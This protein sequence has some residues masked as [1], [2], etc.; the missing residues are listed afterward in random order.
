MANTI[1]LE[2]ADGEYS[3]ALPLERIDELQ[4]KCGAG[5]GAIFARVLKGANRLGDDILLAP[6]QAEFYALDLVET[7][8]QG[9]IGGGKGMVDGKEVK[10][11]P[12]LAQR[13]VASYILNQPL[14][15]AW[16]MAV[17]ILGACIVGYS[18]PGEAAPAEE[19]A[20]ETA[21]ES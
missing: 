19:P 9:L 15:A 5:I 6:G 18:P 7:V 2:F 11:S 16:E 1:D 21:K 4:R 10:V 8:R 13:L 17:A 20:S 14:S 3:F 12:A